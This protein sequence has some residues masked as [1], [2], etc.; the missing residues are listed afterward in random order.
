MRYLNLSELAHVR[1]RAEQ[2]LRSRPPR[3]RST[4]VR[5]YAP[6]PSPRVALLQDVIAGIRRIPAAS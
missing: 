3:R 2:M 5:T 4:R 1:W 6:M